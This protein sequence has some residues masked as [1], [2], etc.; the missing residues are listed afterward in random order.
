MKHDWQSIPVPGALAERPRDNRGYPITF[1]TLIDSNGR[2]DFTTIDAEKIVRCIE[3]QLCGMCGT[4]LVD[5]SRLYDE[6]H[7]VAFIGGPLSIEHRNFLDPPMHEWCAAYAM[8]VCPHIAIDTSRYAK[9]VLGGPEERR[10]FQG[11]HPE[12]PE[13]FGML[14]TAAT[15]VGLVNHQGQ[16]VFLV[17]KAA[18]GEVRWQDEPQ[19]DSDGHELVPYSDDRYYVA[20][21]HD[22]DGEPC[23]QTTIITRGRHRADT[24]REFITVMCPVCSVLVKLNRVTDPDEIARLINPSEED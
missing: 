15:N 3:E 17:D 24:D 5:D 13:R 14:V 7:D 1:V 11:V 10:L 20:Q 23:V 2:P 9:P 8:Q 12:R 19:I 16:P 4:P 6:D 22:S 18:G 21:E